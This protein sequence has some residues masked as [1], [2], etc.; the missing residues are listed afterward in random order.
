MRNYRLENTPCCRKASPRTMAAAVT[1]FNERAL[2]AMG[3]HTRASAVSWT[4]AGTPALS[5]PS[6]NVSP[7]LNCWS[8]KLAVA[9]VVSNTMRP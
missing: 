6:N 1:T 7:A 2:V 3:M 5:R 9:A 4:S 8:V